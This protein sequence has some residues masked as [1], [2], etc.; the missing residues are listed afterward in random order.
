[1]QAG[2]KQGAM[3][4][5]G[6]QEKRQSMNVRKEEGRAQGR[7]AQAGSICVQELFW[8]PQT[9]K[10]PVLKAVSFALETGHF[11][12][13][14]GA[15]GSG[16]T[17]LLRHLLRL[18]PAEKTIGLSGKFLEEWKQRALA[19]MLS[20]VPQNTAVE[21]DFTARE[22][23]M[24]GRTPYI[25][26]FHAPGADDT[27]AVN[28]AMR[29]TN[30]LSFAEKSVLALSGGELQRVLT[31]R[32]IAQET[33]WIFLDEPVSHLDMRHQLELMEVMTRLCKEKA[34]TAVAVL[35]DINLALRYCDE[36]LMMKGG[37]LYAFGK[38]Q[39]VTNAQNLSAVYGLE[40]EE[41]KTAAGER[42]LIP[43]PE[44]CKNRM[45][46]TEQNS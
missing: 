23:V 31:A 42:Y 45:D 14:L 32:A 33:P 18:L 7:N 26:R 34:V 44:K 24:M 5:S 10:E 30:C 11:Y 38:T 22:L 41:V 27:R 37:A 36:V 39:E 21:A 8:Q 28:E 4:M 25:G 15:N 3:K 6:G 16:K 35:H 12:G 9:A 29:M 13:I 20:Y 2:K 40:F 17:S 1:M 46:G 19:Q 43:M